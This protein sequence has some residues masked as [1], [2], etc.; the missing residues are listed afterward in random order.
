MKFMKKDGKDIKEGRCMR[1]KDG[2]LGFSEK[3]RKRIWKNH[4]E[5]IMNKENN[6]DNVTEAS[7]VEG[8]IKNVTREEM[9]IAIKVMKPGKTAGPS[10][11]CAEMI[12]ASGEVGVSV[13][14]ELCQRVLDGKGMPDEWQTSVLVPIFKEKADVKN[15]IL[16]EE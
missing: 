12:S 16:T 14:V 8:P 5:E 4:M 1:G 6:W 9:A 13:I 7:M 15:T 10:E 2:R 3:D 11:V